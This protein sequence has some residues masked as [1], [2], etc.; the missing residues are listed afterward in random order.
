MAIL[1]AEIEELV[2]NYS[3]DGRFDLIKRKLKVTL[4]NC[5]DDI[6]QAVNS[7]SQMN[8]ADVVGSENEPSHVPT[9]DTSI[10]QCLDNYLILSVPTSLSPWNDCI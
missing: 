2:R 1:R 9:N 6:V 5:L 3:P 7:S 10:I 8:L 4:V